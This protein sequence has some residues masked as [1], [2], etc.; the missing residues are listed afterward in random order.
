MSEAGR[1]LDGNGH[2]TTAGSE[3]MLSI[4]PDDARTVVAA[5]ASVL[6]GR[7]SHAALGLLNERTRFRYTGIYRVED[8]LLRNVDLFDRENPMLNVSGAI[9]RLDETYC[10]I[11]AAIG[12]GFTTADAGRDARLVAHAARDSVVAYA[13]VPLRIAGGRVWGTLCHYDVRPRL[14]PEGEL[15]VLEAA[16]PIFAAWLAERATAS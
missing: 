12:N 11:T 5:L 8:P 10:S 16:A 3:H 9:C 6:H 1:R 14:V 13:G 15:D 2:R 4:A 7:G